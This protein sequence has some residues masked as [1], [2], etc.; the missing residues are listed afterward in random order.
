MLYSPVLQLY[1]RDKSN[2]RVSWPIVI[3]ELEKSDFPVW[4]VGQY[5]LV[6]G[7]WRP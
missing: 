4:R 5:G 7:G 3:S 6:S 1:G 2:K